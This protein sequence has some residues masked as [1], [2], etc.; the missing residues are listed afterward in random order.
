MINSTGGNKIVFVLEKTLSIVLIS[1]SVHY[2]HYFILIKLL[3]LC[4]IN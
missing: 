2:M 4:D 3:D 1:F